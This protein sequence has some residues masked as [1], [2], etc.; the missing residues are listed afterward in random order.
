MWNRQEFR[1]IPNKIEALRAEV[2][3]FYSE[4]LRSGEQS[5]VDMVLSHMS[6][7]VA[8]DMVA[9]LLGPYTFKEVRIAHFQMHPSKS[10]GSAV[11]L[12]CSTISIGIHWVRL[13][14]SSQL[15]KT[16]LM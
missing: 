5:G 4:R 1:E 6:W 2:V 14:H 11:F 8:S 16:T 3:R 15:A 10:P 7:R 12:L 9:T 13:L